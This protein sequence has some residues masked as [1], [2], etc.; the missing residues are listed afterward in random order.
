M[1]LVAMEDSVPCLRVTTPTDR[2]GPS[3]MLEIFIPRKLTIGIIRDLS[4][5]GAGGAV[6]YAS[7]FREAVSELADGDDLQPVGDGEGAVKDGE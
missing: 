1:A 6:C 4:A 2:N 3:T 7:G 5:R